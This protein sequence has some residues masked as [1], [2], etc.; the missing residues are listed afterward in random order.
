MS[1]LAF[2]PFGTCIFAG[3]V[4]ELG[5]PSGVN[6]LYKY[7][8]QR[9]D[10]CETEKLSGLIEKKEEIAEKI[11]VLK[12]KREERVSLDFDISRVEKQIRKQLRKYDALIQKIEKEIERLETLRCRIIEEELILLALV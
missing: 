2:P 7:F 9:T 8:L 6:R 1:F 4:E 5:D 10:E 11:E 3:I 12:T